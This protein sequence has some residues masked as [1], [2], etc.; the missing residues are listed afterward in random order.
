[1][2][3]VSVSISS[4]SPLKDPESATVGSAEKL[5][6][7]QATTLQLVYELV[8]SECL[9]MSCSLSDLHH[10]GEEHIETCNQ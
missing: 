6:A 3:V 7:K 10:K 4:P 2:H 9:F 1:M 5:T 8:Q